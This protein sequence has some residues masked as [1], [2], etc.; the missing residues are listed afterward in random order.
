MEICQ[1][2]RSE[3]GWGLCRSSIS[4][5]DHA[6]ETAMGNLPPMVPIEAPRVHWPRTPQA[7]A[8]DGP[9]RT[10]RNKSPR[11]MR[12][13]HKG[14]VPPQNRSLLK[15]T[16]TTTDIEIDFLK[17]SS[18]DCVGPA[19]FPRPTDCRL[20]R[21][22]GVGDMPCLG[23]A[24]ADLG[25]SKCEK[26]AGTAHGKPSKSHPQPVR[27]LGW[28]ICGLK[29]RSSE[30][31][32][33]WE[34]LLEGW[35]PLSF[36]ILELSRTFPWLTGPKSSFSQSLAAYPG[37]R[38]R[39]SEGAGGV[40]LAPSII[41]RKLATPYPLSPILQC[42]PGCTAERPYPKSGNRPS[43]GNE[44]RRPAGAPPNRDGKQRREQ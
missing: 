37:L 40:W 17:H 26:M 21:S 35:R 3:K 20:L 2:A 34:A 27:S 18:P 1:R 29:L 44:C 36:Q 38:E 8:A 10:T 15:A 4:R 25:Y 13:Q 14:V 22:G 43:A 39:S 42:V 28:S 6:L 23:T 30:S 11:C 9:S 16:A 5:S 41:R 32:P 19:N 24:S 7:G 12:A 31:R 33:L